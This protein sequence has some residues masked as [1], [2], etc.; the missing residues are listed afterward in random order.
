MLLITACNEIP[1][2][3][4]SIVN[5][6]GEDIQIWGLTSRGLANQHL[7]N[8]PDGGENAIPR[9]QCI[10]LVVFRHDLT[11][12]ARIDRICRGDPPWVVT[13]EEGVGSRI[14]SGMRAGP[15]KRSRSGA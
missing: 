9:E 3:S 15:R 5:Q 6:T 14:G 2:D 11:E 12:V 8:I 13:E 7:F 10:G 1:A 4:I